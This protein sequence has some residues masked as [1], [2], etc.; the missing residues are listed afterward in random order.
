[1][2]VHGKTSIRFL[3]R[4]ALWLPVILSA[5]AS[6]Q[7][8]SPNGGRAPSPLGP[9]LPTLTDLAADVNSSVYG[10]SFSLTA[11]VVPSKAT[12][13]ITF[14]NG[15]AT[16]G[17]VGLSGGQASFTVSGLPAGI[18]AMAADYSGD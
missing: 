15:T 8:L 12:G 14:K 9:F 6:A 3:A 11:T 18:H 2:T 10:E 17:V 7:T 5:A 13:T 16:L 1:M 4:T